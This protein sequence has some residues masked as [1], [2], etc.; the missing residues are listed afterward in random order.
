MRACLL[1]SRTS[2]WLLL[3]CKKH[4]ICAADCRVLED[5][6]NV[7]SAYVNRNSTGVSLLVG[8]SL[9]ADVDTVLEGDGGRLVVTDIAVKRFE[10]RLVV[11]ASN[12]AV[13]RVSL[14][15]RLAPFLDDLKRLVLM[16]VWMRSLIPR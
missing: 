10:F 2:E 8:C 9:D 16:G 6:F 4:I 14:F 13:K 15:R 5:D 12:I 1:N 11:Y 7:Y 3:Q